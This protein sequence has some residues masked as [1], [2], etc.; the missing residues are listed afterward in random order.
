MNFVQDDIKTAGR[1]P[2]PETIERQRRQQIESLRRLRELLGSDTEESRQD[3]SEL[4]SEALS[5][6]RGI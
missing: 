4:K 3:A 5:W 2:T 1:A 6:A